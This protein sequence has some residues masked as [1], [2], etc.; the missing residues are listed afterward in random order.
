VKRIVT[1]FGGATGFDGAPGGGS[2]FHV[3]LPVL[4]GPADMSTVPIG[5]TSGA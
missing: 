4:N 3:D 2:I 1:R 5:H